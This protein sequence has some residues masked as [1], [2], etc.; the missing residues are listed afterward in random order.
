MDSKVTLAFLAGGNLM[1]LLLLGA[2]RKKYTDTSIRFHFFAQLMMMISYIFAVARFFLPLRIIAAL[3]SSC[4]ILSCYFESL[5]LLSL[6]DL[7]TR[8]A[9]EVQKVV[10]IVG[11]SL[12]CL[13][14]FIVDDLRLRILAIS[15]VVSFLILPAAVRVLR[16]KGISALTA[17]MAV[18]FIVM[19]IGFVIRIVD[20][21]RIGPSLVLFGPSL[22]EIV[23][24]IILYAYLLLGGVGIILLAKENTDA[25]LLRLAHYDGATGAL[26][27]DGFIDAMMTAIDKAS[28]RNE[29][30]SMMLVDIDGLRMINELNGYAVG[31]S[32]IEHT[33]GK[34]RIAAGDQGFVGRLSGDGFIVFLKG[35]DREHLGEAITT[36][37]AS[38]LVDPPL[39]LAYTISIGA[40]AFDSPSKMMLQFPMVHA[41]CAAALA[42]AKKNGYDE[43]VIAET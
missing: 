3:N 7:L 27:R 10:L 41:V 14:A 43:I 5:A 30:F 40:A 12:Y 17:I 15:L 8:R 19:L 9:G 22:G 6:S 26:N 28:F 32:V 1:I 34:L 36:L 37:R 4:V 13:S 24:V 11:L 23:T 21:Y 25:R 20:A 35:V 18:F 2:Y 31:D 39:G 38:V 33:V 42:S 29:A 16:V